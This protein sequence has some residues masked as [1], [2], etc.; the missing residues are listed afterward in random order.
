MS[1]TDIIN[2]AN[3]LSDSY[4]EIDTEFPDELV[5]FV[6]FLSKRGSQLPQDAMQLLHANHLSSTYPNVDILH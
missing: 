4:P 5:H 1:S 2:C 6:H 3:R